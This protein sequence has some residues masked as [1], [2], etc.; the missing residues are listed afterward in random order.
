MQH[1]LPEDDWVAAEAKALLDADPAL[2]ADLR[3]MR[4]EKRAG[5]LT[6]VDTAT[7]RAAIERSVRKARPGE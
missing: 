1:S 2:R 5:T 7:V 3:R 4:A 6:T